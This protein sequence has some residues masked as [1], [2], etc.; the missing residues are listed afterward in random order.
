MTPLLRKRLREQELHDGIVG[1]AQS[2]LL[3]EQHRCPANR[4]EAHS[5]D[6]QRYIRGI[7]RHGGDEDGRIE[8]NELLRRHPGPRKFVDRLKLLDLVAEC[9]LR[10]FAWRPP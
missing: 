3:L 6:H 8:R 7:E 5:W 1:T 10:S 9:L 2:A 4:R